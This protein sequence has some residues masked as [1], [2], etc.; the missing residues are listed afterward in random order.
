NTVTAESLSAYGS[1]SQSIKVV[2][3]KKSFKRSNCYMDDHSFFWTDLAKERPK[4]AFD[5]FY[6]R[7]LKDI[8]DRFG[9]KVTLNCFFHNDHF[10][11]DMTQVPDCWKSEFI[12]NSDW[13]KLSFHSLGE[14]PDRLYIE[15]S[16]EEFAHDYDLVH[17]QIVRF[18]GEETFIAPVVIHWAIIS[19]SCVKVLKERGVRAY[20]SAFRPRLMGGPSAIERAVGNKSSNIART[21]Q[22]ADCS[23]NQLGGDFGFG[24]EEH[25]N[26]MEEASYLDRHRVMYNPFFDVTFFRG[27]CCCNLVPLEVIPGRLKNVFAASDEVG[28]EIFNFG[29]HEQYT[30]PYYHNYIPDHMERI[31]KAAETV[32]QVYGCKPVFFSEGYMG[33][34]AW[35]K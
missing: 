32:Y 23:R 17:D 35:E 3:D 6:L 12:D 25:Y 4:R 10:D 5:H 14:F 33:N 18:A 34:T 11:C 22:N 27:C 8:H 15:A 31:A 13:L 26:V 24:F 20:A 16:E 19:P 29:T 2:W 28:N 21:Q 7:G 30:F 9:L 1:F